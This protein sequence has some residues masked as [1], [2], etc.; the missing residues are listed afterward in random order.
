VV[1]NWSTHRHINGSKSEPAILFT[2]SDVP[3]LEPFGLYREETPGA[4]STH[5]VTS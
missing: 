3:I 4:N 2:L 1:P 5:P